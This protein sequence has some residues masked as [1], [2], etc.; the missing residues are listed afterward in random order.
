MADVQSFEFDLFNH[1]KYKKFID[2]TFLPIVE[3]ICMNMWKELPQH[4]FIYFVYYL[5]YLCLR[6]F[7]F[8]PKRISYTVNIA[9]D[10]DFKVSTLINILNC[11]I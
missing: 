3:L 11:Q 4:R 10:K 9:D 8:C 2:F 7:D 6:V 5:I 1:L